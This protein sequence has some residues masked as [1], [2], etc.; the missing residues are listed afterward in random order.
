MMVHV[1]TEVHA[2]IEPVDVDDAQGV[3]LAKLRGGSGPLF[4]CTPR[5]GARKFVPIAGRRAIAA[6]L[7]VPVQLVHF[8]DD[9]RHL[10]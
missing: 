8:G 7:H 3:H 6:D 9:F 1:I 4:P 5:V 10:A 2:S